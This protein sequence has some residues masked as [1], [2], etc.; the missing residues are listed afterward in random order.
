M[1]ISYSISL[2]SLIFSYPYANNALNPHNQHG[3]YG[4]RQVLH[5]A[6][7]KQCALIIIMWVLH[8]APLKQCALIIIMWVLHF[9]PLKQRELIIIMW[10][11]HFAPLK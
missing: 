3:F 7:L 10:V 2:C 4:P 11:L 9:A 6:P 1:D 8:F 5:F